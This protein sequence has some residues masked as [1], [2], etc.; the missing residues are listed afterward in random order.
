MSGALRISRTAVRQYASGRSTSARRRSDRRN[1]TWATSSPTS[2]EPVSRISNGPWRRSGRGTGLEARA[3]GD[4]RPPD[5]LHVHVHVL[6]T[7]DPPICCA[8]SA[9]A[10]GVDRI[11]PSVAVGRAATNRQRP[12]SSAR[13]RLSCVFFVSWRVFRGLAERRKW[14]LTR[15]SG[16]GP[17]VEVAGVEP[18]SSEP[19][20]I[21]LRAQSTSR[22]RSIHSVVDH[23]WRIQPLRCPAGPGAKPAVS[24][25]G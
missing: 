6:S 21:L 25:S 14:P 18:A 23:R 10:S 4:V 12:R 19:S 7:L 2:R 16:Q 15:A 24:H 1:T 11:A 17:G 3:R 8:R 5:H 22:S 13:T 9:P 20:A